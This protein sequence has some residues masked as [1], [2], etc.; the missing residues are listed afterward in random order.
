MKMTPDQQA[1][2]RRRLDAARAEFTARID[3][4]HQHARDPLERDSEEQAAQLGNVAVVSALEA[5]ATTE[6]AAIDAALVRL[7]AG[8]YGDCIGCGEPIDGKRL[9]ARPASTHCVECAAQAGR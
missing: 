7:A 6:V 3:T 9:A 5:E 2:V 4:I 1:A 8:T